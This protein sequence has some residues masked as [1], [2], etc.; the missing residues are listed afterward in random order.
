L[1][2]VLRGFLGQAEAEANRLHS[3]TLAANLAFLTLRALGNGVAVDTLG[4]QWK[5]VLYIQPRIGVW[6]RPN[7]F[8][9]VGTVEC[10]GKC[11]V[12]DTAPS[13]IQSSSV[14]SSDLLPLVEE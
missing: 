4:N 14:I 13:I 7:S 9:E 5:T 12:L 2:T 8:I 3:G 11:A 6:K 1:A 10:R